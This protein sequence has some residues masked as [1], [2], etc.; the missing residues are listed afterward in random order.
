MILINPIGLAL[1]INKTY[2]SDRLTLSFL[3]IGDGEQGVKAKS[4][5]QG[6]GLKRTQNG[7]AL[8]T[9]YPF[10][11]LPRTY[12]FAPKTPMLEAL[13]GSVPPALG[14][15]GRKMIAFA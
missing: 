7:P 14:A 1:F 13:I 2:D 11:L 12:A 10:T 6:Q 5:R 4:S 3:K 9:F 8:L 15:R